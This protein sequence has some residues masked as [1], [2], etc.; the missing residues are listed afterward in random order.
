M[1]LSGYWS[2]RGGPDPAYLI[3]YS[4]SIT[5]LAVV[6]E[7]PRALLVLFLVTGVPGLTLGFLRFGRMLVLLPLTVIGAFINAMILYYLGVAGRNSPVAASVGPLVVP[8]YAVNATIV[9]GLRIASIAGAGLLLSGLANP[10]DV[11]RSLEALGAP[12]GLVFSLAYALRLLPLLFSELGEVMAVR[13]Q[14][15]YRRV[16]VTPGDYATIML[17]LLSVSVQRAVWVGVSAELRGFRLRRPLRRGPPRPG[18][19]ETLLAAALA[20]QVAAVALL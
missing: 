6:E 13:R 5:L 12:K 17:P 8:W 2:P 1:R 9:I 7:S 11:I 14:R 20:L 3:L 10:R 19:W 15:G 16:P 18:R 4:F